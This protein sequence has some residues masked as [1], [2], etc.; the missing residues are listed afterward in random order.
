MI[1]INKYI[2]DMKKEF[3]ADVNED[4]LMLGIF[5][6]TGQVFSDMLQNSIIMASVTLECTYFIT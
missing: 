5:G 6:Y 4:T 1:E 2:N 3:M